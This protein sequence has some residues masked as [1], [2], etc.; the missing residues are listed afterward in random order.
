MGADMRLIENALPPAASLSLN[1][2]GSAAFDF[3]VGE[4]ARAA[5]QNGETPTGRFMNGRRT[6]ALDYIQSQRRRLIAMKEWEKALEGFDLFIGGGGATNQTGHPAA[7]L[8]Y[9]FGTQGE[10]THEQPRCVTVF[11]QLFA[12]DL[13]LSVAH[14]YQI[15]HDWHTR[16]PALPG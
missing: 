13:L 2:D 14:A 11:G 16:R 12:D 8:P 3:Y 9:R 15:R 4:T 7:V 1:A 10:Q 6:T 5:E